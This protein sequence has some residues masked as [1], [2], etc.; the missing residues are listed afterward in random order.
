M[1]SLDGE[2]ESD[3][4][5]VT[6]GDED[7]Q[8]QAADSAENAAST[9]ES[10]PCQPSSLHLSTEDNG[11]NGFQAHPSSLGDSAEL[12][13]DLLVNSQSQRMNDQRCALDENLVVEN[14][15]ES[16]GEDD[17]FLDLLIGLQVSPSAS[18]SP[19]TL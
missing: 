8:Q 15:A 11:T 17:S 16:I 19:A 18:P 13:F 4:V 9:S 6:T 5:V 14:S 2:L 1:L 7:Q 10:K 12:L 3:F